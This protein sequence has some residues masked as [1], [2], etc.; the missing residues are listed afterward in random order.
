[1]VHEGAAR[2]LGDAGALLP[3]DSGG[4]AHM[5]IENAV[6][7]EELLNDLDAMEDLDQ[8]RVMVVEGAEDEALGQ[9]S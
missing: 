6:V 3:I 1:M 5:L 2:R 8:P 9:L 4:G 7:G